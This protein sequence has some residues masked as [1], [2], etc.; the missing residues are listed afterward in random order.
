MSTENLTA[1]NLKKLPAPKT[2]RVEYFDRGKGG[3]RGLCL[4]VTANGH[5]SWCVFY[6]HKGSLRRYTIGDLEQFGLAAARDRAK[7]ILR[8]AATGEDPQ[9]QKKAGRLGD[10]VRELAEAFI[11]RYSKRQKKT[12]QKDK[13]MIDRDLLPKIGS[14]KG[15]DI[16]RADIRSVLAAI[17]SRGPI[18]ANRSSRSTAASS[19]GAS[20]R[21]W[22]AS[23]STHATASPSPARSVGVNAHLAMMR[24]GQCGQRCQPS[25]R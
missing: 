12:W 14:K 1:R 10:T 16:K 3:V 24:S 19:A 4:R 22:A 21:S 8:R 13:Q 23:P 25:S 5:R 2:G 15:A 17:E 7:D 6:R 18:L 11:E 20:R 9:A